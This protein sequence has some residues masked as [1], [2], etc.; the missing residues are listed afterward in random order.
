MPSFDIVSEVDKHELTNALDQARRELSTRFD[1]RGV[2]ARF[3]QT[4]KG[5][6]LHAENDFQINQMM[7]MLHTAMTKRGIDINCLEEGKVVPSGARV[8]KEVSIRQ[9]LDKE[10]AKKV[11][12]L[13]KDSK[14]KVQP[15]IQGEEVRV[16]GKKRDDL[17][18]VIALLRGNESVGMPLQFKNFRD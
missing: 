16:S 17:Q 7:P 6:T 11:V 13:I 18:E 14:I 15:Q 5:V 3:E 9:G 10:V 8:Y 12:K 2:D 4:E 1:F